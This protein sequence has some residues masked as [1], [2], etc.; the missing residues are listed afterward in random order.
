VVEGI[1]GGGGDAE[2]LALDLGDL[3]AVRRSAEAF[4]ARGE[5]LHLLVNN[6]GLAGP[7]GLT[8]DGFELT[9][10]T[11]HLGPFLFTVL[12][13]PRLRAS[14]PARIVNVASKMHAKAPG[15]GF[16]HWRTSIRS[17]TGTPEYAVSKLCNVL[18]TRSL[19]AGKAG[20]GV[21]SYAVHPGV[22]ASDVWREVPWP[23]RPIMKRFMKSTEE[24]AQTSL[25]CA[26]S[27]DV[28]EHD[29]RY[30]DDCREAT[31]GPL[32]LDAALADSLWAKSA[33]FVG[34]GA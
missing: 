24:G 14:R 7:R 9:V 12:L 11:N 8:K 18:F 25:Y 21:H 28:A 22:I 19:A 32:A 5:A 13:L 30:Y 15:F 29:G 3:A 4:L 34:L 26:T 31:P 33:E 10:G 1:R 16:E 2:F 6:A 20:D 27:P 17:I 23:V